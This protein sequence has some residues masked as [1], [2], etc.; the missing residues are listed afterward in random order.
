[1]LGKAGKHQLEQKRKSVRGRVC[2]AAFALLAVAQAA[3]VQPFAT[4]FEFLP[5]V[6]SGR[7]LT[8]DTQFDRVFATRGELQLK[9]DLFQPVGVDRPTPAIVLVHG[10]SWTFGERWFLHD[11]AADLALQGYTAASVEYRLIPEGGQYPAPV[12]DVLAAVTHLRAGAAELNVDP[13]RIALFGCS[14]GAHLSLLAGLAGDPSVFDPT[15][16][17]NESANIR[18]IVGFY[19]PTDFTVDSASAEPWQVE[20]VADFLGGFQD[21]I[22]DRYREASPVTYVRPDG[23]PVL[24]IHGVLDSVVPVSQGRLLRDALAA[25]GQEH[26]FIELPG[27]GH[28][29]ATFWDS[30]PAQR[31]R[32]SILQFLEAHLRE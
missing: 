26:L 19:G 8:F 6:V 27:A 18:A 24:L 20:L 7:E 11:W 4:F 3:C 32:E 13:E 21:E 29:W 23:P 9:M 25:V 16:P 10:G 12:A 28:F 22:P 17:S 5:L 30:D 31:L 1:M 14:A 2:G 15:L